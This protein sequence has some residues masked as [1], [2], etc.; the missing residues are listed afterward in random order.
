[1]FLLLS[2]C[3]VAVLIGVFSWWK[4]CIIHV[5]WLT[6]QGK[7]QYI[8]S[9][10]AS[11]GAMGVSISR[12]DDSNNQAHFENPLIFV[13]DHPDYVPFPVFPPTLMNRMGFYFRTTSPALSFDVAVSL[14]WWVIA[15]PAGLSVILIV[16]RRR[17]ARITAHLCVHCGYDLRATPERCPECG[18]AVAQSS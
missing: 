12:N 8:L 15:V 5:S 9:G 4:H 17:R 18:T 6:N 13:L 16:N 14:P 3:V 1:M 10:V 2:T 7:S 11:H